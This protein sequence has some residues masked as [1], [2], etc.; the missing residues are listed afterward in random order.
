MEPVGF[1]EAVAEA[2]VVMP[3]SQAAQVD[4]VRSGSGPGNGISGH[5]RDCRTVGSPGRRRCMG[6]HI[7]ATLGERLP[8]IKR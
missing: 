3:E 1:R 6:D 5:S 4:A 8:G 7:P 2:G